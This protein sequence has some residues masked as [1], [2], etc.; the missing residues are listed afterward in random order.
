MGGVGDFAG[1]GGVAGCAGRRDPGDRVAH[2]HDGYR[3]ADG[4]GDGVRRR[5][6]D[7]RGRPGRCPGE[8]VPAGAARG[9]GQRD[10]GAGA[11][12]CACAHRRAGAGDAQRGP[13]RHPRQGRDPAAPARARADP[14]A[15]RVAGRRWLG[16][17]R[18][19]ATT[20][21]ECRRPGC[22]VPRSAGVAVAGGWP[23]GLGEQRG[24]PRGAPRPVR[25]LAAGWRAHR[26]RCR[27]QAD[28][29][30]HRQRD[31]AG[32]TGAPGDVGGDRRARARDRDACGRRAGPD[33]RPR[34]R[35]H[36]GRAGPLPA[37]G[38]SRA[39]AAADQ[40][41]GRRRQRGA[42]VAMPQRAVPASVGPAADARGE[43]VR[44]RRARQPWRGDAGGLQRRPRQ[45]WPDGHV[46]G[47]TGGG[48]RQGQ[49]LRRAGGDP[50]DRRPGASS[51]RRSCPR[52][53]CRGSRGCG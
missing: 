12:R 2:P 46:A 7:P 42:G 24:D 4:N 48:H 52:R 33:R 29:P 43:A 6:P 11:D 49:A 40:R 5:W 26:P 25:R 39:D 30:V 47:A 50:R 10:G 44:G 31:V 1:G 37:P 22:R 28:R 16:P 8:A 13:G 41:D 27:R 51:T 36:P 34:C 32:R 20:L 45:P 15:R 18:L 19:A 53:T 35:H 14:Q 17:E 9:R 21:P 38:R 3:A 23:C